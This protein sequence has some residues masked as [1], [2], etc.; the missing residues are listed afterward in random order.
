MKIEEKDVKPKLSNG[1]LKAWVMIE[2][3][4]VKQEI[5]KQSLE[6]LSK[7]IDKEQE[8]GIIKKEFKESTK[9][10]NPLPNIPEAYSTIL[11]LEILAKN[12]GSLV[13]FVMNYGPS[14][15]EILEPKSIDI[16]L[17]EAQN[18]LSEIANMIHRFAQAGVGGIILSKGGNQG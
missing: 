3:L 7:I 10:E 9:V 16:E 2:S 6:E 14:A 12:Y 17:G 1:W 18:V 8:L 11:E 15:I 13:R 5:S 4:A